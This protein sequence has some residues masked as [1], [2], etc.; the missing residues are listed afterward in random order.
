MAFTALLRVTTRALSTL[1]TFEILKGPS[2]M[3]SGMAPND[4][5]GGVINYVTKHAGDED[6]K[7]GDP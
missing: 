4:T 7:Y 2:A 1:K 6:K 3:L 5:V